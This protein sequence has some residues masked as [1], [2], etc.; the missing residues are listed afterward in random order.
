[1]AYS[2]LLF[3]LDNTLFDFTAASNEALKSFAELL[4]VEYNDDFLNVYHG[5]NHEVWTSFEAG[6]I[7]SMTLRKTRFEKTAKHYGRTI[8][9][10]IMNRK[11]LKL[12]VKYKRFMDGAEDILDY[13]EKS[14]I[15]GAITNG[16][17]EV[18]R[19]RLKEAGIYNK[20][21]VIVV[22]DEIG[23]AKPDTRYFDH[24]WE[25]LDKPAKEKVLVIGDNPNSDI[26]GANNFGFHSCFFDPKDTNQK[27]ECNYRIQH[28]S[29]L[30]A[31][32]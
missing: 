6:L 15:L 17:K 7:D 27:I 19:P 22:S 12:L 31:I 9:G 13:Y 2:H 21:E 1:M 24:A 8:D 3:D 16:L 29:E 11:Y 20:F 25:L 5:Y 10:L 14:H 28:L 26:L 32:T 23:I 18:Q 4:Q 30:K